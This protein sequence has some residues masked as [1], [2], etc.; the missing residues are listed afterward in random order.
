MTASLADGG[1]IPAASE[2]TVD[3]IAGAPAGDILREIT[4]GGVAGLIVGV[5]LAGVG[6]RVA[7]RLAALLVPSAAGSITEN[8]N[9]IGVI[10]IPGSLALISIVGLFFGAVAGSLWVIINPWLPRRPRTRAIVAVPIAIGLATSALVDDR[11]PDFVVLRHDAV[12]IGLLVVLVGLFGPALVLAE[13]WLDRRLPHA[14]PGDGRLIAG[15]VLVAALGTLLTLA[16]V[17][18][19]YLGSRLVVAG[20]GLFVVGFA[21]LASWR[22]RAT[23][24]PSPPWLAPVARTGLVVASAAGLVV[25]AGDLAGA[26]ALG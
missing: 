16:A 21:T 14:H 22:L 8:G 11:N 26:L 13:R 9:V 12:V 18:P 15:Y 3:P 2:P 5:L 4:R 1:G 7:M 24:R 23:R 17:L 25:A 6:G 20:L 19:L 10:T